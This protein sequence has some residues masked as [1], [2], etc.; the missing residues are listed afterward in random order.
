MIGSSCLLPVR[1]PKIFREDYAPLTIDDG[2]LNASAPKMIVLPLLSF[3][4]GES[5]T[6]SM[7]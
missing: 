2:E 1:C 7:I 6:F 5:P 3:K 4:L